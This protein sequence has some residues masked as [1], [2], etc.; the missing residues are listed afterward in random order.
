MTWL[1]HLRFYKQYI[2]NSGWFRGIQILLGW[3]K[4]KQVPPIAGIANYIIGFKRHGLRMEDN[5]WLAVPWLLGK[6]FTTCFSQADFLFQNGKDVGHRVKKKFPKCSKPKS[7]NSLF[8][9]SCPPIS[10]LHYLSFNQRCQFCGECQAVSSPCLFIFI[11]ESASWSFNHCKTW[12]SGI[13]G[14]KKNG[15]KKSGP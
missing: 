15:W 13:F 10:W 7:P 5:F 6:P 12:A 14:V 3:R 1:V 4:T 9:T 11:L 8:N 2:N